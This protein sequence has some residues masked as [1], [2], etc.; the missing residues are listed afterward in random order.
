MLHMKIINKQF[1]RI[2]KVSIGLLYML[3][4][5]G[6][7]QLTDLKDKN[8]VKKNINLIKERKVSSLANHVHYPFKRE[9]PLSSIRN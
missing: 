3:T 2:A 6:Y 1:K 9:Y 7:A 5:Y 8:T 4:N